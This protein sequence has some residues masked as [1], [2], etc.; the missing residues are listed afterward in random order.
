MNRLAEH[1]G[2]DGP[3]PAIEGVD[4]AAMARAQ[5]V[6][7]RTIDD[8]ATLLATLDAELWPRKTPLLLEIVVA[9]DPSFE[10]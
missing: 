7:A 5:G 6:E 10:A 1:A 4:I 3:W 2:S 8:H 9:Q